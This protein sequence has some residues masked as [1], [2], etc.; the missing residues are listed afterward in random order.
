[1][2]GG[3]LDKV[4]DWCEDDVGVKLFKFRGKGF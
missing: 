2:C 4:S 1:M 3:V